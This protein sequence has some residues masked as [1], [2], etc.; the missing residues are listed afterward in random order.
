M[1]E[2]INDTDKEVCELEKLNNYIKYVVN[3]L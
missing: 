2:I 1:F 3:E